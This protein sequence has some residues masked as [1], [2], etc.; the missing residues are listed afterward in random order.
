MPTFQYTARDKSGNSASGRMDADN[1]QDMLQKL[2]DKGLIPTSVSD[3]HSARAQDT[4]KALAGKGLRRGKKIKSEEMILFTRSLATMVNAG[5]PLLQGIDIMIEQTES[6]NFKRV[7]TQIGQDIEAGLTFSDALKKHP[8]VFTDLYAS[9]VRAGEASGNLDGILIQ[10]AEYL[11]ATE[12]LKREIKS[13]MTYPIIALVIVVAIA[14]GLLVFIVPKFQE[15]FEGLGG[16]LPA[17][18]LMLIKLSNILRSYILIVI[19][20]LVAIFVGVRYYVSTPLGKMQ[21]DTVKLRLPVFGPLFRKVAVARFART[22]STLTRSGVPVLAALEIVERTIGNEVIA[23][24]VNGSQSSIKAGATISE[25]LSR[26]GAFPLMVTRMIDVG[27]RTGA[28]DELLGKIAEF[29][30]QQVEATISSLTSLIE[31]MLILF[32]GI[33]VGGMVLAL[34]L[35]IFKL[36]TLVG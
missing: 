32:L 22:L 28:L 15:I 9:M 16:Q 31:P 12:K 26:S 34:F 30:D 24:A 4:K 23:R 1:K 33:V 13:A 7:L 27:E 21:F 11:E 14:V 29:Y 5:L 18:T 35:P 2:R 17:P 25:P 3:T 6:A 20:I 10:L 19:G 8:K 36:S